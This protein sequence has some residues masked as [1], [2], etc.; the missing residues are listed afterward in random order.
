VNTNKNHPVLLITIGLLLV[1]GLSGVVLRFT[2]GHAL[3]N[4]GSYV[5]WG[6]W[7]SGYIYFVGLSAGAFLL[8]SMV[9]VFGVE[10][11]RR[12]ARPALLLAAVTLAMA[13]LCIW[14][15][16]G[17]QWRAYEVFTRPN[18]SSIMAWMVWLYTAYFILI[19]VELWYEVRVDVS[20]L[21]RSRG[22][23]APVYRILL[24][25]W[26]AP[27][28]GK[29]LETAR[30]RSRKKLRILGAI[31]IPLAIA[32]H[33]GVGA[34]FATL[35]ARPYWHSALYPVLFLTG[36]L[37]S[38]GA[39]LLAVAAFTRAGD[40]EDGRRARWFLRRLVAGLL[41]FDL[42]LEW[43][44]ISVPSWYRIGEDF[45]LLKVIL[46]GDFWYVFWIFHILLG[47]V[48]PMWL[49]LGKAG[50]SAAGY[51]GVLVA[52]TFL[53][54]R[55]N[56]VIPGLVTPRIAGIQDAY[57]DHRLLFS[58][59]PSMFEWSVMGFVVALGIT[60]FLIGRWLL[61]LA[62]KSTTQGV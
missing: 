23:L 34:L 8:S 31:G 7:V 18:F 6:L 20:E 36:A 42:I 27:A 40:G 21:A 59:V 3:A 50:R 9:Y 43:A 2:Q 1:W 47:A 4:Y 5:P 26:S 14:F 54:V 30:E 25:G 56:L 57:V 28:E 35:T 51:A 52:T 16:L 17:H 41:A 15:D 19:L 38:G 61:P 58:Y 45:E 62:E 48:I 37:V 55:L 12:V 49:L 10:S 29:R 13:L 33:G 22:R 39:L 46:F 44:E 53:A 24:F 60:L 32:F 11:L